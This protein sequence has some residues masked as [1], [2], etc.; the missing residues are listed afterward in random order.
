MPRY[1]YNNQ[2]RK[3]GRDPQR[4][5]PPKQIITVLQAIQ[6]LTYLSE[7]IKFGTDDYHAIILI[8]RRQAEDYRQLQAD[9]AALQASFAEATRPRTRVPRKETDQWDSPERID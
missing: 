4:T 2:L 7:N 3:W 9:Y 6:H 8:L 5:R 1:K